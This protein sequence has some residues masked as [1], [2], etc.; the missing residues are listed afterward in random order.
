MTGTV[1]KTSHSTVLII[2]DKASSVFEMEICMVVG[3]EKESGF[4]SSHVISTSV[5]DVETRERTTRCACD[6]FG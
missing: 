6:G 1:L 2:L 4:D 3:R 5:K